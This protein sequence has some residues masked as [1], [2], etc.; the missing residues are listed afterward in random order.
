MDKIIDIFNIKTTPQ[1]AGFLLVIN[2]QKNK[3][4]FKQKD[5]NILYHLRN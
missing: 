2:F 1:L 5:K 3:K 4:N